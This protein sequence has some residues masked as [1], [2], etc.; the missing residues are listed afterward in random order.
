MRQVVWEKAVKDGE[1]RGGVKRGNRGASQREKKYKDLPIIHIAYNL[2]CM[3]SLLG[4]I[5]AIGNSFFA[6]N[7]EQQGQ[8]MSNF[9]HTSLRTQHLSVKHAH[10]KQHQRSQCIRPGHGKDRATRRTVFTYM[11]GAGS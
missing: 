10:A 6:V 9:K 5:G 1:Y 7:C 4:A 11:R 8:R 3:K 2:E